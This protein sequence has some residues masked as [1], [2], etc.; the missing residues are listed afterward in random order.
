[1]FVYQQPSFFLSLSKVRD[2]R[3][4]KKLAFEQNTNKI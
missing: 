1:M 2:N 3:K 4:P